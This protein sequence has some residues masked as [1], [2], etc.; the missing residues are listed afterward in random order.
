MQKQKK[1]CMPSRKKKKT[2][3]SGSAN[4]QMHLLRFLCSTTNNSAIKI[5]LDKTC[6]WTITCR[7]AFGLRMIKANPKE[8]GIHHLTLIGNM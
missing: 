4:A 8:S 6:L 3:Q 1:A 5:T 2:V 7:L